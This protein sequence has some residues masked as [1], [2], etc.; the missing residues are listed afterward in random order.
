MQSVFGTDNPYNNYFIGAFLSHEN[1]LIDPCNFD[2]TKDFMF[3]V[4]QNNLLQG[5]LGIPEILL[6][7]V[8]LKLERVKR[9]LFTVAEFSFI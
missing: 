6:C 3:A 7:L 4:S 8:P 9:F 1:I 5:L 2:F